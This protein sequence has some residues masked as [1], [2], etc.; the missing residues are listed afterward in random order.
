MSNPFFDR[1]ILNSPYERPARHWELDR[2]GQPTQK[3]VDTRRKAEFFS[4]IPTPRKRKGRR[5]LNDGA[6]LGTR[7]GDHFR[8]VT[9]MVA[10][11]DWMTSWLRTRGSQP[12]L[13]GGHRRASERAQAALGAAR[14]LPEGGRSNLVIPIQSSFAK[15]RFPRIPALGDDAAAKALGLSLT[16][17]GLDASLMN[18]VGP[19]PHGRRGTARRPSVRER[20]LGLRARDFA[21]S[22]DRRSDPPAQELHAA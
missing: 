21:R 7:E 1:P 12:S 4:P 14:S 13:R 5:P 20:C 16:Y 19:Q 10:A 15:P 11:R 6:W 17:G 3:I 9:K 8:D 2:D 22:R 18:G